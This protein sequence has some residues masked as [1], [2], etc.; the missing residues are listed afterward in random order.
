MKCS[1]ILAIAL[2]FAISSSATGDARKGEKSP[3][4]GAVSGTAFWSGPAYRGSLP[5]RYGTAHPRDWVGASDAEYFALEDAIVIAT[6][7]VMTAH[8]GRQS[9]DRSRTEETWPR[10]IPARLSCSAVGAKLTCSHV[11]VL[12]GDRLLVSNDSN[13][14]FALRLIRNGQTER[15][16]ELPPASEDVEIDVGGLGDGVYSFVDAGT[17][18]RLG[19]VYRAN[20]EANV[21]GPTNGNCRFSIG[22]RSGRYRIVTWHPYLAPVEQVAVVRAGRISR[23]NPVFSQSNVVP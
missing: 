9:D 20:R 5:L 17:N 19:W 15:A 12:Q 22:L 8:T 2:L 7:I 21:A 3:S 6:P 10:E 13:R 14:Q 11:V 4:Y 23:V 1:P 16:I 18:E